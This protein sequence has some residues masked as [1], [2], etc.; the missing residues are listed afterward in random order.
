MAEFDHLCIWRLR[1]IKEKRRDAVDTATVACEHDR[2]RFLRHGRKH[3]SKRL[4]LHPRLDWSNSQTLDALELWRHAKLAQLR[5]GDSLGR[6]CTCLPLTATTVC[7]CFARRFLSI[8]MAFPFQ[9]RL[10]CQ[11][12]CRP[13]RPR[14]LVSCPVI[15]HGLFAG[16]SACEIVPCSFTWFSVLTVDVGHVICGRR[17]I[18]SALIVL[19]LL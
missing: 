11:L 14:C 10:C 8:R 16:G 5:S 3:S 12:C 18:Y 1:S 4:R 6:F 19:T 17:M 13:P 15:W 7:A 9:K 2:R